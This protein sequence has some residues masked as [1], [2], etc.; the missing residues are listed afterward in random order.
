MNEADAG[1][2]MKQMANAYATAGLAS[3]ALLT[4]TAGL[5]WPPAV[6]PAMK[7]KT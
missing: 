6:S 5:A 7:S 4:K 1:G 3:P 2:N